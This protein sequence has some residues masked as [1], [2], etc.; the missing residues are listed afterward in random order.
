MQGNF[1]PKMMEALQG[2][3]ATGNWEDALKEMNMTPEEV[4]QKIMSDPEL[5]GVRSLTCCCIPFKLPLTH[6]TV[7]R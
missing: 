4:I 2:D 6:V 3:A 1:D 7:L 5:A